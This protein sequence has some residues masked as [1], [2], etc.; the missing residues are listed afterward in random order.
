M[1][2]NYMLQGVMN[3]RID[4]H[5]FP[6]TH[7]ELCVGSPLT[8]KLKKDHQVSVGRHNLHKKS[9]VTRLPGYLV[10]HMVRFA[11]RQDIGKKAKIMVLIALYFPRCPDTLG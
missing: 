7:L 6:R 1:G 2:T 9:R 5:N 4:L 11:W 8:K 3:V 10:V